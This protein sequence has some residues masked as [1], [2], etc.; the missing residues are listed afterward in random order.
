MRFL[1]DGHC[2]AHTV[3]QVKGNVLEIGVGTGRNLQYYDA[4]CALTATDISPEML[5]VARVKSDQ[6]VKDGDSTAAVQFVRHHT[7]VPCSHACALLFLMQFNCD[8]T[9]FVVVLYVIPYRQIYLYIC[10]FVSQ[11]LFLSI[12]ISIF[13]CCQFHAE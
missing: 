6:L 10:T 5:A 11:S 12:P 9:N 4:T 3:S 1:S 7:G 2:F 8:F 13:V